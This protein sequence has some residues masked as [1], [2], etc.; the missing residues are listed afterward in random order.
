MLMRFTSQ[1][2]A[3]QSFLSKLT[4]LALLGASLLLSVGTGTAASAAETVQFKYNQ[5][6]VS[7]PLG[8][9]RTFVETG[10]LRQAVRDFFNLN[11]QE[12]GPVGKLLAAEVRIPQNLGSSFLD[13][14]AGEFVL[15]QLD[16]VVQGADDLRTLRST[17]QASIDDDRNISVLEI[18]S[19]YPGSTI[20]LDLTSLSGVYGDVTA[21]VER[22]LPA[23]EV[24][25]GYLQDLVC[26]CPTAAPGAAPASAV[27]TSTEPAAA[28]K[29]ISPQSFV[30][31]AA[32]GAQP[33]Q[34]S[35]SA[36]VAPPAAPLSPASAHSDS[37]GN[38][39]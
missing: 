17:L 28:P 3:N 29:A 31:A 13:S 4:S 12:A 15:F 2:R 10:E 14:S 9:V 16:K 39:L 27:P 32:V 21:F 18:L 37:V 19:R 7:V 8:E 6:E 1:H 33:C 24:A 5:S 35:A 36:P 34:R 11:S 30:P 26:D 22:I 23:L 20:T 38:T 25:K